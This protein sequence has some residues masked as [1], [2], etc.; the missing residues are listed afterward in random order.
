MWLFVYITNVLLVM[1]N[2]IPQKKLNSDG[3]Q[4]VVQLQKY[5]KIILISL[6]KI[7]NADICKQ[8]SIYYHHTKRCACGNAD[9]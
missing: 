8:C 1:L 9:T 2:I 6:G 5:K 7:K 4:I 3:Y